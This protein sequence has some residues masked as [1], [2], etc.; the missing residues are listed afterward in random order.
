[1]K[2]VEVG[3]NQTCE[4]VRE[5]VGRPVVNMVTEMESV[6]VRLVRRGEYE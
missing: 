4:V 6:C 1:M 5:V 3:E 2:L